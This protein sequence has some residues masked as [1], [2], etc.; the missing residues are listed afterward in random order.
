MVT[1][2]TV[3]LNAA[4]RGRLRVVLG[5]FHCRVVQRGFRRVVDGPLQRSCEVGLLAFWNLVFEMFSLRFMYIVY[6]YNDAVMLV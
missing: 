1:V 3:D 6:V 2:V 5:R 4:L